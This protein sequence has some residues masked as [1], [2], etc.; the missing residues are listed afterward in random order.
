MV[1]LAG[2]SSWNLLCGF[3]TKSPYFGDPV[4]ALGSFGK[5]TAVCAATDGCEH[6][7]YD[8]T[9]YLKKAVTGY[10]RTNN[11]VNRIAVKV[12]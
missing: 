5:C 7:A 10:I 3:D 8:G 2:G 4:Y 1:T 12:D 11:S 9:C 6:V